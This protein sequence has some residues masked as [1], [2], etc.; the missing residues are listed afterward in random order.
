MRPSCAGAHVVGPAGGG[1]RRLPPGNPATL[2]YVPASWQTPAMTQS[3]CVVVVVCVCLEVGGS[4]SQE[5]GGGLA[6][7]LA[8]HSL[9]RWSAQRLMGMLLRHSSELNC[10]PKLS[11]SSCRQR[12]GEALSGRPCGRLGRQQ[13][14]AT[15]KLAA[16][17]CA[18]S[19]T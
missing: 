13:K 2:A 7:G 12:G 16:V 10:T 4:G 9:A 3:V 17:G 6:A 14:E 15:R 8:A 5:E 1:K 18:T 19:S 11:A